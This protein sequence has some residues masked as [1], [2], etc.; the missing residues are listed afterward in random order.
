MS[1]FETVRMGSPTHDICTVIIFGAS[2]DL[3]KR[4][5]IPA[6][7]RLM[8]SEGPGVSFHVVGIGKDPMGVEQ[9]R[10]HLHEG[11]RASKEVATLS[12]RDW[13]SFARHI[14]YFHA[15]LTAAET[16][17]ELASRLDVL[18]ATGGSANRLFYCST[19]PSLAGAILDGLKHAG[20]ADEAKGWSRVVIEKPFGR[21]LESA[22]ALNE[23]VA[24]NFKEQQV[25]R[26][27]HYL[28][29]ET[30]Q[31]LLVFRFGNILFEP[32]WNRNYVE[33]VEITAAE[34]VGTG[35]RAGYYEEAGALRDMVANH[36]LQL[37]TLVA[38]EPP[39]AFDADSVREEKV[40]V[41]RS[42]RPMTPDEV[43]QRTVRGQYEAGEVGGA[44]VPGY[45]TEPGV[46]ESSSTETYV[47]VQFGI[48]NWRWAG[49]PFYVRTGKRLARQL[50][51]INVHF[52]RTPHA[53]FA[54]V[55]DNAI[56]PNV[57]SLRIQPDEAVR[58]TFGAKRP[59]TEMRTATVQMDFAYETGFGVQSPTAYETLLLDAMNGEAT[60][61]TRRDEVENEWRLIT[62]ILD[63]WRS[64]PP[65]VA[66]YDAGTSGPSAADILLARNGHAWR[67][68]VRKGPSAIKGRTGI[69][70]WPATRM[71]S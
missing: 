65:S 2:G 69:L 31:N 52:K 17:D 43:A 33:Y 61:F 21:D 6:L 4:K 38:M 23:I 25:Y 58:V 40:Q 13:E 14:H 62:P 15:D 51:E 39:V 28:G 48:Q 53:L 27:D 46:S 50:T 44:E 55:A 67:P 36:L 70:T 49:V 30:V 29:K 24:A 22:R 71:L 16:Y 68:L 10:A 60:L 66:P 11:I 57:V 7:F 47:A 12:E 54:D 34:M 42:I 35:G 41:L 59:G 3:T 5:L 20:L 56:Q 18:A 8:S 32:V 1:G 26:I 19:P 64:M 9:F 63:V 37:L 45:R